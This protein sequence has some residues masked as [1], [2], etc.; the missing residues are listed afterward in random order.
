MK[1]MIFLPLLFLFFC[2]NGETH[3]GSHSGN[4]KTIIVKVAVA[5]DRISSEWK[6]AITG[7]MHA[8]KLDSFCRLRRVLTAKEE[9]WVSLIKSKKE[10][11]NDFRDSLAVPFKDVFLSDTITVMLGY[12]GQDDG[13][14]YKA[15]TVCID[16]TALQKEYGDADLA[17]NDNRI[18]RIFA[19]EYTHLLHKMWAANNGVQPKTFKDSI[20]WE[21]WYEGVGMYRSLNSKWLPVD[22]NLPMLAKNSLEE[23]CPVFTDRLMTIGNKTGITE[24]EKETLQKNLSR[25]PVNKKWGAFPVAIWLVLEAKGNDTNL[26]ALISKGPCSVL[27]LARKYLPKELSGKLPRS[28]SEVFPCL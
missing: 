16:V 21:C 13:F 9:T 14:T 28:Y 11:W 20:L 18:D 2:S 4:K 19:H 26:T 5:G 3:P 23:L 10:R 17:E 12:L 7:R 25:G 6:D 27:E 8:A 24:A 1:Q 15:A 22:G